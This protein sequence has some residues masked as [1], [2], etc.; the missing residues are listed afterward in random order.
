[1]YKF[2]SFNSAPKHQQPQREEVKQLPP[3]PDPFFI[4]KKGDLEYFR[5]GKFKESIEY[6]RQFDPGNDSNPEEESNLLERERK[7]M[8]RRKQP[9]EVDFIANDESLLKRLGYCV[10]EDQNG[11]LL[12]HPEILNLVSSSHHLE[13]YKGI[14][15]ASTIDL[16]N[17][18][19]C[20]YHERRNFLKGHLDDQIVKMCLPRNTLEQCP[21][22]EQIYYSRLASLDFLSLRIDDLLLSPELKH[23]CYP[24]Y[25]KMLYESGRTERF[26]DVL[27]T[28]YEMKFSRPTYSES[29]IPQQLMRNILSRNG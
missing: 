18:T 3:E 16:I 17:W 15:M 10:E 28:V 6:A 4:D 9:K 25:L 19:L 21:K 7:G 23:N 2:P 22:A 11:N 26:I 20:D 8:E 24:F 13:L 1:M 5:Y 12:S 29:P 14:S 27:Q